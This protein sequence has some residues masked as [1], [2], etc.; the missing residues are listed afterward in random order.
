MEREA[1]AGK[2]GPKAPRF[3]QLRVPA[4]KILQI[5]RTPK[6]LTLYVQRTHSGRNHANSPE[7]ASP[8]A[9]DLFASARRCAPDVDSPASSSGVLL[10]PSATY[11][12]FGRCSARASSTPTAPRGISTAS[13]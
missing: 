13:R 6:A 10:L 3:D 1:E 11:S 8:T 12:L 4:V 2:G 9:P 7:R 5:S